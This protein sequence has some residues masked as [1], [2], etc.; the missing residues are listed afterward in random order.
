[1]VQLRKYVTVLTPSTLVSKTVVLGARE[2]NTVQTGEAVQMSVQNIDR[3]V[4]AGEEGG[5]EIQQG[6]DYGAGPIDVVWNINVH[7][8][9]PNI[10]CS[11]VRLS[12][13][14]RAGVKIS[15]TTSFRSA[16][17]RRQPSGGE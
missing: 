14:K 13:Q 3:L 4:E 7:P 8:A 16:R 2:H 12:R 15:K 11:F 5:F 1:M 10:K 17:W 9:L 6:V